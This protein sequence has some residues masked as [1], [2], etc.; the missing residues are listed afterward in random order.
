MGRV[1]R[2]SDAAHG[3]GEV[4]F[5][6]GFDGGQ[7]GVEARTVPRVELLLELARLLGATQVLVE[8]TAEHEYAADKEVEQADD[9]GD[10]Q[11]VG[12]PKEDV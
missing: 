6:R 9:D 1:G 8:E 2:G 3:L 5:G 12:D 4:A 11:P 10:Q 7:K